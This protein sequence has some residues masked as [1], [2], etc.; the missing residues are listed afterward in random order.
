MAEFGFYPGYGLS[1]VNA[2]VAW[3]GKPDFLQLHGDIRDWPNFISS[4]RGNV[5]ESEKY[6]IDDAKKVGVKLQIT[7]PAFPRGGN[8]TDAAAGK[9]NGYYDDSAKAIDAALGDIAYEPVF[10]SWVEWNG[11][12]MLWS[13]YT[14]ADGK[15]VAAGFRHQVDAFRRY[16]PKAIIDWNYNRGEKPPMWGWPGDEYVDVISWDGY[17]E[18]QYVGQ[19]DGAA[20]FERFRTE[21]YGLDWL[22]NFARSKGKLM[23]ISETGL[24]SVSDKQGAAYLR[25]MRAW[26]V[27]NL[28]VLAWVSPFLETFDPK[29]SSQWE[30][31]ELRASGNNAR[32]LS[33]QAMVELRD[34]IRGKQPSG[35]ITP[36]VV[37]PPVT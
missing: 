26:C 9:Y 22:A 31:V 17:I 8:I 21:G 24:K 25:A 33:M 35:A 34:A 12:W 36:P 10:R 14:E 28:D 7:Q 16:R 1:R 4:M 27:K 23:A 29:K 32:P 3:L 5:D 6:T 15:K 20:V 18:A 19:E 2:I 13:A 11:R 37:T 30:D